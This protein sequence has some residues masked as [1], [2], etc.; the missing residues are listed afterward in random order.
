MKWAIENSNLDFYIRR[1]RSVHQN[2]VSHQER[3]LQ[4]NSSY[5]IYSYNSHET[6]YTCI[7]VNFI[8]SAS[9]IAS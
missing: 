4:E 1:P 6:H 7:P 9:D 2:I 5:T 3:R 8:S